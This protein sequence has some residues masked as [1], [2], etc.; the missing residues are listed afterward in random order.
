MWNLHG[1]FMVNFSAAV[2]GYKENRVYEILPYIGIGFAHAWY[3]S[4]PTRND[5][6]ANFGIVQKFCVSPAIDINLEVSQML[7][8]D[9]FD[10]VDENGIIDGSSV[11]SVGI[12]YKF[13][14]RGFDR[15]IPARSRLTLCWRN[16]PITTRR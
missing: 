10:G 13:K 1:D 15:G 4:A 16:R 5:M 8:N 14:K 3:K 7:V 9:A 11:I 2:F 12:T 6:T